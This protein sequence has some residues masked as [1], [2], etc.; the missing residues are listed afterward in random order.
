[1]LTIDEE[2]PHPLCLGRISQYNHDNQMFSGVALGLVQSKCHLT[3][4]V[5]VSEL[6]D[7]TGFRS[8]KARAFH[9]FSGLGVQLFGVSDISVRWHTSGTDAMH[10]PCA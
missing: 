4:N 1:M 8:F 6:L 7:I 5:Q 10:E 3:F 9:G 2:L